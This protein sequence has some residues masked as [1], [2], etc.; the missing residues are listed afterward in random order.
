MAAGSIWVKLLCVALLARL[1]N[2]TQGWLLEKTMKT[3]IAIV[4]LA[5]VI[6]SP[7]LAQT[8]TRRAPIPQNPSQ[9]DQPIDQS[10]GRSEARPR[11]GIPGN[12]VYDNNHYLGSDPDSNV[13]LDLR[14]DFEGRDF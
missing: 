2:Y 4:T 1:L 5:A 6:A 9:F 11:S 10:V 7:V 13:R 3:L 8:P 12:A 14:R